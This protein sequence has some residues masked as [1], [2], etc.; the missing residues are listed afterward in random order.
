MELVKNI[1]NIESDRI[2]K[3]FDGFTITQISD[4][5][6]RKI[7]CSFYDLIDGDIVVLTGDIIGG[8]VKNAN[9]VICIIKNIAKTKPV[10]YITGNH[11]AANAILFYRIEKELERCNNVKILHDNSVLI[12]RGTDCINLIGLDDLEFLQKTQ[13]RDISIQDNRLQS[14]DMSDY[15]IVLLHSPNNIETVA[16]CNPDLVLSGHTHGGQ[17]R[18]PK[19][20][21]IYAPG[22]GLFP[23]YDKGQYKVR[24]TDLIISSGIGYSRIPLRINCPA[25]INN[26]VLHNIGE[27]HNNKQ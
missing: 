9:D 16:K 20:G 1:Y 27:T 25:E 12:S 24:N 11:E 4:L 6:S 8:K 18:L 23:K 15:T 2:P 14:F 22:Q 10:Y 19:I 26:I 7:N 13:G 3:A 17:W 21:S 5:H